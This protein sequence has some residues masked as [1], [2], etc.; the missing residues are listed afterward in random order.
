MARARLS[1]CAALALVAIAAA[2]GCGSAGRGSTR[3]ASTPATKAPAAFA[4]LGRAPAPAGWSRV[5]TTSG[6]TLAY[7][8]GWRSLRGDSGTVSAALLDASG[9]FL[10]YLNITPR[11]ANER[12]V[13]WGSFRVMHNRAEGDRAVRLLA[14]E[15]GVRFRSGSGACVQDSYTTSVGTRYVELACLIGGAH[16]AVV[17]GAA[18]PQRWAP[19]SQT[20]SRA[21]SAAVL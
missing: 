10:A 11:Q 2:V 14:V 19:E 16:P 1:T 7:P 8:P 17:V 9:R 5:S 15:H 18:P 3:A 21:I 13:T 12:Q 20:I 6:I 4:L